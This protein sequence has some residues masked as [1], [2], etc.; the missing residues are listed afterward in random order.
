MTMMLCLPDAGRKVAWTN[1]EEIKHDTKVSNSIQE[2]N[3]LLLCGCG[4]IL[5]TYFL[6]LHLYLCLQL[7]Y[8]II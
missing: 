4:F 2:G 3:V 5:S 8:V 7:P 6:Y 1:M